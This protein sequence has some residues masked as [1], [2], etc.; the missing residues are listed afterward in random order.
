MGRFSHS[1]FRIGKSDP[2]LQ[3]TDVG[4]RFSSKGT[5]S[6]S[7]PRSSM[8]RSRIVMT[9]SAVSTSAS[10]RIS[11]LLRTTCTCRFIFLILRRKPSSSSSSGCSHQPSRT[12]GPMGTP[13]SVATSG[14]KSP[15]SWHLAASR[16]QKV[17]S[18]CRLAFQA[19]FTIALCSLFKLK[20]RFTFLLYW[21][22]VSG[23]SLESCI[24]P[25]VSTNTAC[26]VGGESGLGESKARPKTRCRVVCGFGD[27]IET[28]TPTSS[29]IKDDFPELGTPR[30]Q[31]CPLRSRNRVSTP[32]PASSSSSPTVASASS[33]SCASSSSGDCWR[34]LSSRSMS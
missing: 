11:I 16:T 12:V 10:S 2:G 20:A 25:A 9:N 31:T 30:T 4:Q 24:M 34:A 17:A 27:T 6:S 14:M 33:A 32:L 13:S 21:P 23:G 29:L 19:V 1:H 18:T 26:V 15:Y 3:S 7:V 28:L 5:P 8:S 22:P